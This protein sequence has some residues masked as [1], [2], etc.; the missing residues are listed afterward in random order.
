MIRYEVL[1]D[2]PKQCADRLYTRRVLSTLAV[3]L[4][5]VLGVR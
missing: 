3:V 4:Q 1:K 2:K 5:A